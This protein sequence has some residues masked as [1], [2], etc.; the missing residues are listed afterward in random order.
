MAPRTVTVIRLES[1]DGERLEVELGAGTMVDI[2]ALVD[3]FWRRR[4]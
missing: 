2:A 4:G 1:R 3:A